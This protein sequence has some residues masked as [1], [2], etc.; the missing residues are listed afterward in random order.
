[1]LLVLLVLLVQVPLALLVL[2]V[3]QQRLQ[4]GLLQ[5]GTLVRLLRLPMMVQLK[6][7]S[8]VFLFPEE[9]QEPPA[10]LVL[11]AQMGL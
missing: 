11:L 3:Q 10:Q 6:M 2:L 8:L 5:Q 7:R 4:S 1:M 9:Q